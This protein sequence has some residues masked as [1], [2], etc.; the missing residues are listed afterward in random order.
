[1]WYGKKALTAILWLKEAH[2]DMTLWEQPPTI[3]PSSNR[4]KCYVWPWPVFEGHR[5]QSRGQISRK[6]IKLDFLA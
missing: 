5:G 1:M 4:K 3:W 2:F 6:C